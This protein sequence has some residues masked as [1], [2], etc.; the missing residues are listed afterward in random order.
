MQNKIHQMV[1]LADLIQT[2]ATSL[3]LNVYTNNNNTVGWPDF[4]VIY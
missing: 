2:V 4:Y 3:L 1:G